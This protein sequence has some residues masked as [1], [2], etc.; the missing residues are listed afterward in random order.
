MIT[1]DA[2]I[3]I[4]KVAE[5]WNRR[6]CN[7]K[8]SKSEFLSKRYFDEVEEKKYFVEPHIKEF[9]DFGAWK[10]KRV[11]EIGCG[12]GTDSVNF[13]KN[14]AELTIVELSEKSLEICKKR[15][16]LFGLKANF[17][18]GNAEKLS[19][20]LPSQNFD[21]VYS[22]GVLH[23]TPN[24]EKAISEINK[25][26]TDGELRIM[27]Y[28]KFSYKLFQIMRET[29]QWDFSKASEIIQKYSEA[30]I[31]CPCTYTYT[32]DEITDLLKSFEVKKIYKDHI[33]PFRFPEYNDNLYVIDNAFDGMSSSEFKKLEKELGWHTM[34]IAKKKQNG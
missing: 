8:H 30:Q 13:A 23:H 29:N 14:G 3:D 21:L 9:A 4:D 22:F 18:T 1:L 15:F 25:Y 20:I 11:L 6:P 12:I 32:F 5:F 27:L 26:I 28:S 31:G 2:N 34:V 33:F 17:Y 24:P 10:G 7:I 19:E 16:E